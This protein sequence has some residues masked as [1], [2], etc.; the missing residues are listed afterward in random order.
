MQQI[1]DSSMNGSFQLPN[2]SNFASEMFEPA[3]KYRKRKKNV[4]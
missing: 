3:Q 1:Q 4:L 2:D